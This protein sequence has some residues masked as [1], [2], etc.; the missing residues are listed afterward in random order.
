MGSLGLALGVLLGATLVGESYP[1]SD[2]PIGAEIMLAGGVFLGFTFGI[3]GMTAG[4]LAADA[5]PEWHQE[6]SA[7]SREWRQEYPEPGR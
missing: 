6:Y 3:V 1:L 4:A 2:D 5:P 7:G